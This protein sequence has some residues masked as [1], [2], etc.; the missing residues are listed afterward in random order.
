MSPYRENGL[1][2]PRPRRDYEALV[3]GAA[4]ALAG[5]YGTFSIAMGGCT[6]NVL[7]PIDTAALKD[8]LELEGRIYCGSD[9]GMY[10]SARSR[11]G[12]M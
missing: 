1:R 2:P 9:G 8:S 11:A 12:R 3:L 10:W 7:G 4:T 6:T 5:L